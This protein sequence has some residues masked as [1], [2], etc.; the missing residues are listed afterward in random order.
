MNDLMNR[1]ARNRVVHRLEALDT[2]IRSTLSSLL[3]KHKTAAKSAKLNK[4]KRHQNSKTSKC[5]P[6]RIWRRQATWEQKWP[7][8]LSSFLN[9]PRK[10]GKTAPAANSTKKNH[11]LNIYI[12][13]CFYVFVLV[14]HSVFDTF[15]DNW[16]LPSLTLLTPLKVHKSTHPERLHF[17]VFALKT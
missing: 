2:L 7:S 3:S 14:F 10:P 16:R 6:T 11:F 13:K 4:K 17:Q 15:S 12:Y 5:S 1:S 9:Q 8:N